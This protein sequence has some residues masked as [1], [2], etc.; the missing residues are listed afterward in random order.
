MTKDILLAAVT[1]AQGLKGEV[2]VKTFTQ[3]SEALRAY[4]VLHDAKGKTYEIAAFRV[5]KPGEA[6][7]AFKG[8][9]DRDAAEALKGT[10][11]FVKRGALPATDENEFYHADLIGLEAFDGEGRQIGRIAA[12]H[13]F[14]AGDVI[15]I[16]RN[17]LDG[18][19]GDEVLLAFTR[20]TVP[21]IDIAGGRVTIAVPEEDEADGPHPNVE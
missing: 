13:N 3:A 17:A 9:S 1:G 11:L 2:K 10:E 20:E 21:V 14:G 5:S 19:G 18:S 16:A 15:V 8:I 4:G 7:I 12:I 6:V